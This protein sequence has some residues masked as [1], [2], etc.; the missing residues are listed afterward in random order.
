MIFDYQI[1]KILSLTFLTLDAALSTLKRLR[2]IEDTLILKV[3]DMYHMKVQ[4]LMFKI[5][6]IDF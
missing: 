3:I 4:D 6:P 2:G 1:S 5:L